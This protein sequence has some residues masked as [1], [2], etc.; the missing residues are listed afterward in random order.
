MRNFA[1][2]GFKLGFATDVESV[3]RNQSEVG[4]YYVSKNISLLQIE[5]V[6]SGHSTGFV[7][8]AEPWRIKSIVKDALKEFPV[9]PEPF[10]RRLSLPT[11]VS[12]TVA[13]KP[14]PCFSRSITSTMMVL[15]TERTDIPA[16]DLISGLRNMAFRRI[17]RSFAATVT[18]VNT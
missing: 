2:A 11:E 4:V 3:H 18:G 9:N 14:R 5:S 17:S 10:D 13:E 8:C 15:N 6:Y 16:R 12:A 1:Y 7:G